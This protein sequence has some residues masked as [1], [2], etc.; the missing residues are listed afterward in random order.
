MDNL[1]KINFIM[2]DDSP[3]GDEWRDVDQ[4]RTYKSVSG[5][6]RSAK[7]RLTE[8]YGCFEPAYDVAI[9]VRG[10]RVTSYYRVSE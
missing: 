4:W 10:E 6:K 5:A 8:E 1:P 7:S 2:M 9:S 3:A